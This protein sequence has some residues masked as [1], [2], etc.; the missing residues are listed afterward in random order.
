MTDTPLH[1]IPKE[2]LSAY[3]RWEMASLD[4]A[5]VATRSVPAAPGGGNGAATA[6]AAHAAEL[7]ALREEARAEGFAAGQRDGLARAAAQVERLNQLLQ[8]L[9]HAVEGHEQRLADAVLD[10]SL[11]LARQLAGEALAVR[12]E[13]LVPLI[14]DALGQLPELTQRVRLHLDPA[15]V[16]LVRTLT[17]AHP[18]LEMCQL[19]PDPTVGAGGFRMETEQCAI[20]GTLDTRWQRLAGNFGRSYEWLDHT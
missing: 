5:P 1:F 4:A 13:M 2:T 3:Q 18:G 7:A 11:V 8:S 6:E 9:G 16:E 10:T 20:D 17:D 12:R 14:A 19:V 15:D